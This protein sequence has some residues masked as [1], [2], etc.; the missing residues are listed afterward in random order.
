[1]KDKNYTEY[2]EQY[3][4]LSDGSLVTSQYLVANFPWPVGKD[5]GIML[6]TLVTPE[7]ELFV[8][9]NGR[10][11]GKWGYKEDALDMFIH[12]HRLS[13][14]GDDLS[15]HLENTM[16][17]VD[18]SLKSNQ[19]SLDHKRY[20]S[21]DGFI[22][23]SIYAPQLR[24]YGN[25]QLGPEAGFKPSGPVHNVDSATGFGVHVLMTDKVDKLIKNWT[26]VLGLGNDGPKPFL[27]AITRPDE[28][29]DIIFKLFDGD[30][31]VDSFSDV[32]I[33]YNNMIN[34]KDASY[35][36]SID[37][38]AKGEKGEIKGTIKFTKKFAH[39][40]LKQHLNF[41]ERSFA[42]SNPSVTNFRYLIDYDLVYKTS[43]GETSLTGKALGEYTDI[44]PTRKA[45]V[46]R[47]RSRR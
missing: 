43:E 6:G 16:G 32:K 3:F 38:S 17:I 4:Y 22:E 24:G 9:K 46:K 37:I 10:D 29:Q 13:G 23:T 39:F 42:K 5:H 47:R 36:K 19:A 28:A 34:E 45:P 15:V 30:V 12:T 27:S 2:W 11:P 14:S 44:S 26:R 35:P 33:S 7:G 18:L 31:T 40:N 25:W 8:I 21:E 41:F 1:M 20:S